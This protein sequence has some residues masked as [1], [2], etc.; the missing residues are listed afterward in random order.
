MEERLLKYFRD[1]EA[2]IFG[3]LER[4]VKAEA[5]TSDLEALAETR[6][7]LEALIR[8]RTG[9]EPLVYEREGGHDLVRFELGQGEEKLLIIGHYDTVHLIGAIQYRT[10]G[11]RLY[12][13]GVSDMKSG[14]ISAIWTARAYKELGIDPGRKLVFIFNGDEETGSHES[15]DIICGLAENARAALVCEPCVGNGDL[16][17]G[18]KG[19]IKFN[20]TIH[21]KASHAGNAHKEGINAI[22]EMAAEIL[23]IQALT[24]YEAGTTVNV[25][26][27]QGGTKVNVVPAAASFSVDCRYKIYGGGPE[28]PTGDPGIA[29]ICSWCVQGGGDRGREA[30]HGGDPGEHGAVC[31][32]EGMRQ[33]AGTFVSHQ[34]VGGGSDGNAVSAMGIPTLDG[35]GGWGDGA[36]SESEYLRI[37][38]Y[39]PRIA[40][41]ASLILD[42]R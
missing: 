32:C 40:L 13:P 7:V 26:I 29:D 5:S 9:E 31:G 1:H 28:D 25:G 8:E 16:K 12:G 24:D 36:H 14:L 23:K 10:E 11:D 19:N 21:G 20:V 37:S 35:L 2:E 6:K 30:S 15:S 17:T 38:Q 22:Q 41:L 3:D 33:E 27:C 42:I 18:R 39:I 34:F 4:L